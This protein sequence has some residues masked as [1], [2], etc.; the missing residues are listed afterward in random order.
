MQGEN[1]TLEQTFLWRESMNGDAVDQ[2]L[3]SKT[4]VS[5]LALKI[6]S[7]QI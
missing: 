6:S 1:V 2:H 5:Y 4:T 7:S 3:I